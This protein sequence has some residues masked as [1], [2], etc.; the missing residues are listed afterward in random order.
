MCE[1]ERGLQVDCFVEEGSYL[2]HHQVSNVW[3][4]RKLNGTGLF[5]D[6]KS[7]PFRRMHENKPVHLNSRAMAQ[8]NEAVS[9]SMCTSSSLDVAKTKIPG[10][11]PQPEPGL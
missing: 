8:F 2:S 4:V 11:G 9:S 10:E 1:R 7:L 5:S 3:T 6:G